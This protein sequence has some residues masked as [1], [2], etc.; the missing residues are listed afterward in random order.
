MSVTLSLFVGSSI[1]GKK[2]AFFATLSR[3][4]DPDRST[5]ST[6]EQHFF[7]VQN[8]KPRARKIVRAW[9]LRCGEVGA[10]K[11]ALFCLLRA[12]RAL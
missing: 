4:S 10:V 1:L 6:R 11:E 2:P 8:E 5:R 3:F 9:K 12:P 7:L